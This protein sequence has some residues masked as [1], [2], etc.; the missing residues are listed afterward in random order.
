[1]IEAKHNKLLRRI[2]NRYIKYQFKK[3]FN[4]FYVVDEVPTFYDEKSILI[5]PNHFSWWDGFFVDLIYR[6]FFNDYKIYM[7]VLEETI[8]RYWFFNKIGA[9]TINQ[10][11]TKDIISSFRYASMLLSKKKNLVVIFPQGELQSYS[12]NIQLKPGVIDLILK[13]NSDFHLIFLGMKIEFSN[14]KKPE[15]YYRLSYSNKL[16]EYLN[17]SQIFI[18]DFNKNLK[19]LELNIKLG[20]KQKIII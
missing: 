14:Q 13:R 12:T 3:Y 15:V 20:S 9:F 10:N 11:N 8:K 5:L 4:N 7:M 2:F 19:D 1:M 6:S 18:D 16:N 17:S